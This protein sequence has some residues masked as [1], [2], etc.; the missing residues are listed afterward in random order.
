[1]N[2]EKQKKYKNELIKKE[3]YVDILII[4]NKQEVAVVF[5]T[6]ENKDNL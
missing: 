3:Y 5:K 2:F 1:M 6:R 4:R